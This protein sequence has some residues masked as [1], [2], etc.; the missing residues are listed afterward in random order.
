MV[1][2]SDGAAA[3]SDGSSS[4][5]SD[6]V[7]ARTLTHRPVEQG[8]LAGLVEHAVPQTDLAERDP[9]YV[10]R[11][12]AEIWPLLHVW[13]RPR[14]RG[15]ENIPASGPVLM[16]GNHSGGN[17][18]PDTSIFTAA[19]VH[20]FGA[21]RPF[22]QLAHDLVLAMPQTRILQLPKYGTVTASHEHAEA[23]LRAGA[24]LLVY[25]GG[26]YETHRPSWRANEVDFGG[27]TGFIRLAL[28]TDV[29]I[30]PVVSIGGQE[31]ALFLSRGSGLAHMLHLD[32]ALR[33]KVLPISLALPWGLNVGDMLGHL[34]LPAQISIE[35]LPP[36]DLRKQFGRE[37]DIEDIYDHI[38][39]RMQATLDELAAN[40]HIPLIG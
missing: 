40:R 23:A 27:R 20:H 25:P 37:P 33:L 7:S 24:A 34:P 36:I 38:V 1:R 3:N 35:V 13:F 30:V 4:D 32:S 12:L 26:D 2:A 5:G 9:A 14:I 39:G 15:M 11:H 6:A 18:A 10:S 21:E 17:M 16:V 8:W 31:T 29:P 28:H 22:Y 19:F